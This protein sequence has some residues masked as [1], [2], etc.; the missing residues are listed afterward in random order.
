MDPSR[1]QGI[2]AYRMVVRLR[3]ASG[4]AGQTAHGGRE[5]IRRP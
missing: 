3:S 5:L 1:A 2:V 4:P